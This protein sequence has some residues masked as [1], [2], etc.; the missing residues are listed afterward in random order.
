M[1]VCVPVHTERSLG[2]EIF[3]PPAGPVNKQNK[4]TNTPPPLPDFLAAL[5]FA[6]PLSS[7]LCYLSWLTISITAGFMVGFSNR[8][9]ELLHGGEKTTLKWRALHWTYW[10]SQWF[11]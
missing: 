3:A 2:I 5:P 9:I 11:S 1:C 7:G 4:N 6:F 10:K 8:C